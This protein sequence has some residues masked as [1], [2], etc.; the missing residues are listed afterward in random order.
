MLEKNL[1]IEEMDGV[2]FWDMIEFRKLFPE[3]IKLMLK[4][5]IFD[6]IVHVSFEVMFVGIWYI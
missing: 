3:I 4:Y 6:S 2:I 5:K 1:P